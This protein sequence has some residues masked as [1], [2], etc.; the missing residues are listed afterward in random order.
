MQGSDNKMSDDFWKGE[1]KGNQ[2]GP[3]HPKKQTDGRGCAGRA[4]YRAM[5]QDPATCWDGQAAGNRQKKGVSLEPHLLAASVFSSVLYLPEPSRGQRSQC[6]CNTGC[7]TAHRGPPRQTQSHN[8]QPV[9]A[10][11]SPRAAPLVSFQQLYGEG[12]IHVPVPQMGK[13]MRGVVMN[14]SRGR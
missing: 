9:W 10:W 13:L 2:R 5:A 11:Q 1:K 4:W 7:T 14:I 3:I 12:T 8:W 6:V